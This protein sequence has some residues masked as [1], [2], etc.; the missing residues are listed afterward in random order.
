M[1]YQRVLKY[2]GINFKLNF[3]NNLSLFIPILFAAFLIGCNNNPSGPSNAPARVQGKVT[4]SSS[5]NKIEKTNAVQNNI[6]G[7]TVILSEVKS[8]GSLETV[9]NAAV[10]TDANGNFIIET[11]LDGVSDL[12]VVA[13][14]DSSQWKAIV[15]AEVK[16]G[17]TVNTQPV[18]DESTAQADVYVKAKSEND[19]EVTSTIIQNYINSKIAAEIKGNSGLEIQAASAL[20]A[21]AQAEAQTASSSSFNVSQSQWQQIMNSQA[22]ANAQL[23]TDLNNSSS[24]SEDNSYETYYQNLAAA[25]T[26][27]GLT[28]DT[29][30]KILEISHEVFLN[31]ASKLNS[32]LAFD[33][34]QSAAVIRAKVI[35]YAVQS[36]FGELGASS[37]EIQDIMNSSAALNSSIAN[38]GSSSDID[39]AFSVFHDK[40]LSALKI[41]FNSSSNNVVMIDSS[42]A[43]LK[44]ELRSSISANDSI[45]LLISAY[46]KFYLK[47]FNAV[48]A[49]MSSTNNNQI[50]STSDTFIL[51]YAN[52]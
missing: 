18:D 5:M 3:T 14:K 22:E 50:K 23:E 38:A 29:Y 7:A 49:M 20:N 9:S 12:I 33:F 52:N 25:Y 21:E 6:Q 42:V 40:I 39:N 10:Q 43:A 13:T 44:A 36:K 4:G 32:Q 45:D 41:V 48:S 37:V 19:N 16:S 28:V 2:L 35:S 1:K 30:G 15:S 24:L 26:K 47:V 27:A 34:E 17:I 46:S 31:A 51:L 11:N 8:D